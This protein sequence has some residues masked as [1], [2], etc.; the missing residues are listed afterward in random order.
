VH[1]QLHDGIFVQHY[2]DM[3]CCFFLLP[4]MRINSFVA[5]AATA[6]ISGTRVRVGQMTGCRSSSLAFAVCAR[7]AG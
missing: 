1:R 4:L 2:I 7:A 6:V 3:C 5:P